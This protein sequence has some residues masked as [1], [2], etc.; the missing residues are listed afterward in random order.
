VNAVSVAVAVAGD[1]CPRVEDRPD[2]ADAS[3]ATELAGV[4]ALDREHI[5]PEPLGV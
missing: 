2:A 1:A 4:A 5:E 3:T